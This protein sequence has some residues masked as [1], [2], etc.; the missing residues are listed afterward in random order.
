MR[1]VA[2]DVLVPVRPPHLEVT[3]YKGKIRGTLGFGLFLKGYPWFWLV[4]KSAIFAHSAPEPVPRSFEISD[5]S[6]TQETLCYV[7]FRAFRVS[8][9]GT[10]WFVIR[11][12]PSGGQD[13]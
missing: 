7:G 12:P 3:F 8:L 1:F 2:G 11:P 10:L 4:F 6:E 13:L 9:R 5:T